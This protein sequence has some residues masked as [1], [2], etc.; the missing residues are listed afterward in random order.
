M[1]LGFTT[2]HTVDCQPLTMYSLTWSRSLMALMSYYH[3]VDFLAASKMSLAVGVLFA[4]LG[5]FTYLIAVC[6]YQAT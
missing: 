6:L 2:S 5:N 3:A 4:V 1:A